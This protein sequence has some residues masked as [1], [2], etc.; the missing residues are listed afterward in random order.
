[1]AAAAV[2]SHTVL[3]V[4]AGVLFWIT[5][6]D[7][8]DF[9]IRNEFILVLAGLFFLYALLSGRWVELHWHLG[10]AALMC[11][12]MLLA[13][14]RGLMG[15]GDVK[16]LAVAF[17]WTGVRCV[18]LFLLALTV[19]ALLHAFAARLGWVRAQRENGQTR[20]AFAPSVAIG[21]LAVF[22]LG[23]LAPIALSTAD[24]LHRLSL[25]QQLS[26]NHL[27]FS[28]FPCN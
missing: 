1:M 11:A 22:L 21:L 14:A 25:C 6:A 10:F 2:A 5:V 23:C 24:S 4:T 27:P 17:L 8:R 7:L 12:L 18:V 26:I 20:I 16:L 19:F 13:Y 9:R 28:L 15:G 3:V